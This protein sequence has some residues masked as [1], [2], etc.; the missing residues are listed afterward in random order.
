M[1][2]R[3]RDSREESWK[4]LGG[5]WLPNSQ[6]QNQSSESHRVILIFIVAMNHVWLFD[7]V[8]KRRIIKAGKGVPW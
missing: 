1:C 7:F 3:G 4:G 6:P 2:R 5:H 8:V